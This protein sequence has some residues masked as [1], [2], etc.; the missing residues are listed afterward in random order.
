MADHNPSPYCSVEKPLLAKIE[1]FVLIRWFMTARPQ[2][3][4]L[5]T[6]RLVAITS[7]MLMVIRRICLLL[8]T[9]TPMPTGGSEDSP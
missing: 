9:C 5:P 1:P 6:I 3:S 8:T 7:P 2:T 4:R